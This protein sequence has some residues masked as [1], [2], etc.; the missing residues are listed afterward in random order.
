MKDDRLTARVAKKLR[1]RLRN[2]LIAAASPSSN[3]SF[4]EKDVKAI[5][6]FNWTEQCHDLK[7]TAPLLSIVLE[8][9]AEARKSKVRGAKKDVVVAVIAGILLRNSS[10]RV[11][12]L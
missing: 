5:C 1:R 3:S 9:L 8:N 2:K 12:F 11:S 6:S 4:R 10:Q 7:R